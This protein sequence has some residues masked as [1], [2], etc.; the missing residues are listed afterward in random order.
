MAAVSRALPWRLSLGRRPHGAG[1]RGRTVAG[2]SFLLL[3]N[4]HHEPI[5]FRLP[6]LAGG[7]RWLTVLDTA[8]DGGL[9]RGGAIESGATYG[10]QGR[11]LV[12]L[13]QQSAG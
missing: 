11:A 3:F 1:R 5:E 4:A 12:L 10:L 2:Y 7:A 13:Q 9:A 6:Q 8:H